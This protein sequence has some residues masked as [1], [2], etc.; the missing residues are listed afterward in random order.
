MRPRAYGQLIALCTVLLLNA[1]AATA[2]GVTWHESFEA[3]VTAAGES[4]RPILA[5]FHSVGC[6]P[7]AQ[8]EQET[9]ADPEVAAV[10]AERFEGVQVNALH[11]P[12]L[13]TRYLVSH[14][15]TVKFFDA[16][17]AAVYDCQGFVPAVDF[18]GIMNEAAEAHAALLRARQAA[19]DTPAGAQER[20]AIAR[21]FLRAGQH[22]S[23][24]E[25]ARTA[26][27]AGNAE[28]AGVVAEAQY[29]LGVAL[30][31]AGE[32]GRAEEPL[33]TALTM[34]DGAAWAW[35]A[36]LTLGYVWLQRGNEDAGA[37]LL[38]AVYASDEAPADV[39]EE[40]GRLLRWWGVE[41]D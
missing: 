18:V 5:A 9:L 40:S 27:D 6:G 7:C 25:W 20:L 16:S 13:A 28:T 22:L 4:G 29:V 10:I 8:M 2:D 26:L 24:A 19:E 1:A 39:R 23:S 15:P 38:R 41:L 32:P 21:D 12:D 31:E 34:A 33:V 37:D 17:G 3:A 11:Q 30:T 14:Y 36:R 35:D